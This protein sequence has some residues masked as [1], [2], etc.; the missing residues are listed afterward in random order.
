MGEEKE[1]TEAGDKVEREVIEVEETGENQHMKIT[2]DNVVEEEPKNMVKLVFKEKSDSN[3]ETEV[4]SGQPQNDTFR[5]LSTTV[6]PE[7]KDHGDNVMVEEVDKKTVEE[8]EKTRGEEEVVEDDEQIGEK[9]LP[10]LDHLL[11]WAATASPSDRLRL[12]NNMAEVQAKLFN[13]HMK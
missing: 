5:S 12:M 2:E 13:I 6:S 9:E 7:E 10:C 8:K 1:V 4:T 3:E 11:P